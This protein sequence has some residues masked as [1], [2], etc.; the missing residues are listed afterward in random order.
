MPN[1]SLYSFSGNF[2]LI[3][4]ELIHV[5]KLLHDASAVLF[6]KLSLYLP[7]QFTNQNLSTKSIFN[8][9]IPSH[10]P[11]LTGFKRNRSYIVKIYQLSFQYSYLEN[12]FE[13]SEINHSDV[14]NASQREV[15]PSNK[16]NRKSLTPLAPGLVKEITSF[17]KSQEFKAQ[18]RRNCDFMRNILR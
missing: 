12:L 9:Q 15:K 11:V 1:G 2:Y 6:E 10:L 5:G 8:N 7:T 13:N 3:L 16:C 14:T 4:N 17:I 18:A